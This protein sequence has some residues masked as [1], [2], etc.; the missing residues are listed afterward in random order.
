MKVPIVQFL[1]KPIL[2]Y[3]DPI[4][5]VDQYDNNLY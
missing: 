5:V 3:L 1:L 2:F 4:C